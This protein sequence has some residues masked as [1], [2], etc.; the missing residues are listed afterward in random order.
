MES[1]PDGERIVGFVSSGPSRSQQF[2]LAGEV[3]ALYLLRSEHGRGIG[4]RLWD[5]ALDDLRERDLCPGF[6]WVLAD[7]RAAGFY[8]HLGAEEIGRRVCDIPGASHLEE[9]ALRF[10]C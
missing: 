2:G 6:V 3:L 9:I 8:R 1:S 10:D 7:N 5:A 4:R